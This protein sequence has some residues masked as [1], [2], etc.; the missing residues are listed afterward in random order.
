MATDVLAFMDAVHECARNRDFVA[1]FN[2]LTGCHLGEPCSPLDVA[3]DEVTGWEREQLGRFVTFVAEFVW[4]P[5][6][7]GASPEGGEGR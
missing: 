7:A 4:M 1:E 5:L 2:R 6:L 3:I